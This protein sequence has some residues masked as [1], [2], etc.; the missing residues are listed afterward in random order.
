MALSLVWLMDSMK[1]YERVAMRES[2]MGES[3]VGLKDFLMET[4]SDSLMKMMDNYLV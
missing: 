4:H 2:L 3:S 1:R